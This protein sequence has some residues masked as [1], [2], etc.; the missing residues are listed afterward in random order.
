MVEEF[1]TKDVFR[2][3]DGFLVMMNILSTLHSS[4]RVA[5]TDEELV[6]RMEVARLALAM[7]SE[8]MSNHPLNRDYFE[9]PSLS[10]HV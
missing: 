5:E 3:L 8:A 4:N 9:V 1:A 2:E 7:T 6:K 10:F